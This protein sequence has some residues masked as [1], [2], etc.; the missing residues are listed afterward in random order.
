M[1]AYQIRQEDH[2]NVS[3]FKTLESGKIILELGRRNKNIEMRVAYSGFQ[4]WSTWQWVAA[5]ALV[6]YFDSS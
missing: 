5:D 3:T 1:A 2:R 6:S 4:G